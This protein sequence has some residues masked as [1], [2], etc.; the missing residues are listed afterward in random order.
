VKN[1]VKTIS[2]RLGNETRRHLTMRLK[3]QLIEKLAEA[4]ATDNCSVSS[5]VEREMERVIRTRKPKK[6]TGFFA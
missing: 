6:M 2:P 3:P 4:A 5:M 1:D